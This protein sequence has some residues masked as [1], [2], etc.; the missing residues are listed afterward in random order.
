MKIGNVS[1]VQQQDQ[2]A[3]KKQTTQP[4]FTCTTEKYMYIFYKVNDK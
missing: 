4:I 1:Q 3:K 2:R